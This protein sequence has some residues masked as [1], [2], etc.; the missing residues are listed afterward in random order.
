MAADTKYN[1]WDNSD[2]RVRGYLFLNE[3]KGLCPFKPNILLPHREQTIRRMKA[4]KTV[5]CI[6]DGSDLNY[7]TL[8]KCEGLGVIGT[9]QTGAQSRG[10]HLHSTLAINTDGLPLGVHF[11]LPPNN[12]YLHQTKACV[13]PGYIPRAKTFTADSERRDAP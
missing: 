3:L 11:S 10:L 12:E 5:L 1:G 13:G 2:M 7:S 9:N 8:D 6:Q 4:E